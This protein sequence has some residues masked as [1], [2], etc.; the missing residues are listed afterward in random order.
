MEI[1]ELRIDTSPEPSDIEFLESQIN[2]F[3]ISTTGFNDGK[4][5][6][7]FVRDPSGAIVAGIYGWT[8]GACCEIRYL[9][10]AQ[11][12]RGAGHGSRLLAAAEREA[13]ARGCFQIVLDTHEFQAPLFYQ[14]HGY[15]IMGIIDDYPQGY[16]KYYLRK[17]LNQRWP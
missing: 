4:L 17:T 1:D 2:R 6:A 8:W 11:E 3:N 5:L 16:H 13:T 7:I 14:R 9:W 10:V 12:S 15:E